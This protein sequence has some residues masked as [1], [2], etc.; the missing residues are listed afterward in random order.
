MSCLAYLYYFYGTNKFDLI[1]F[2]RS[3]KVIET[4]AIRN[5]GYRFLFAFYSNYMARYSVLF[6]ENRELFIPHPYLAPPQVVTPS[7]FREDV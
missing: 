4:G 2:E 7:Q 5:L 1:W 3:L 6:V